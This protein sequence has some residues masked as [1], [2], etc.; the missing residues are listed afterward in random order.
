MQ[1]DFHDG[2][3]YIV[4][5]LAGFEHEGASIVAYC[6]QYVDDAINAGLIQFDNGTIC[7][8]ISWAHKM[9]DYR[10][11]QELVNYQVWIP[12]HF[13]PGNG[14]KKAGEDP[15]GK[16]I[17]ELICRPNSDVAQQMVRECIQH[18]DSAYGL[19]CIIWVLQCT[20]MLT[21]GRIKVL[22]V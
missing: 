14:T 8:R 6:A 15:E 1:I 13:L 22:L 9:L 16:F 12:F 19:V 3:T 10:N 17:E 4:A 2:V 7:S 20:L 18:R 11:F 21:S 5:R